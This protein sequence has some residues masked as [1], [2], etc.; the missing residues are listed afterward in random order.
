MPFIS[1]E[2]KI[3]KKVVSYLLARFKDNNPDFDFRKMVPKIQEIQQYVSKDVL[4]QF[5]NEVLVKKSNFDKDYLSGLV[6]CLLTGEVLA[7]FYPTDEL[8]PLTNARNDAE[9]YTF[10][11]KFVEA[12]TSEHDRRQQNDTDRNLRRLD[13]L[14]RILSLNI[15]HSACVAVAI[16]QGQLVVASNV[17]GR[18][19]AEEVTQALIK[20]IATLKRLVQSCPHTHF[21]GI[22]EFCCQP[23]NTNKLHSLLGSGVTIS[24]LRQSLAKVIHVLKTNEYEFCPE[25]QNAF[26][27]ESPLIFLTAE[28]IRGEM[29]LRCSTLKSQM[30]AVNVVALPATPDKESLQ[31]DIHAEQMVKVYLQRF[32]SPSNSVQIRI[33]LS[34]LCCR[35][36]FDFFAVEPGFLVRGTH[37]NAHKGTV[38][39]HTGARIKHNSD[40]HGPSNPMDSVLLSPCKSSFLMTRLLIEEYDPA[41]ALENSQENRCSPHQFFTPRNLFKEGAF[42]LIEDELPKDEPMD[43]SDFV[44][45]D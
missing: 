13:S 39:L 12:H 8:N 21:L 26:N 17:S 30:L 40:Y 14:A 45:F 37:N 18:S 11:S 2:H 20:K 4:L 24:S 35:T 25:F 34:K 1:F 38:N 16:H 6:D 23:E 28:K 22:Y 3:T 33:G 7:K 15:S 9:L 43:F 44:L 19:T 27:E 29:A 41:E 32:L 5:L 42:G 31:K 10:I 36:C